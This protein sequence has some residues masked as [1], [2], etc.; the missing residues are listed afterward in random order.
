[1]KIGVLEPEYFLESNIKRIE[2]KIGKVFLY[3]DLTNLNDFIKDKDVIFIRLKYNINKDIL[4][5]AKKLKIICSPTTGL[6]H[7]DLN[8]ITT[9]KI[10]LI[11]LKGKAKFLNQIRATPENTIGLSL[12]LLRKYKLFFCN[13]VSKNKRYQHLGDELFGMKVGIIGYGRVGKLVSKYLKAFGSIIN[14]YDIK[15]VN[16]LRGIIIKESL[17][18]LI[19]CSDLIFLTASF[20]G[21]KILE[22]E[23]LD[24]MKNKY[25]INTSRGELIDEAYLLKKVSGNHFKGVAIDVISN[26]NNLSN[27]NL[28]VIEKLITKSNFIYTPHISGATLNSLSKVE[29]YITKELIKKYLDK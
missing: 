15:K 25:L 12:A 9:K 3:D 6:N 17:K 13:N 2:E 29:T 20:N 14:I 19:N 1:M 8:Y 11:S 26:E 24:L 28:K 4:K 22:K 10:K 18:E 23:H 21:K 27:N 16:P 7:L 5:D